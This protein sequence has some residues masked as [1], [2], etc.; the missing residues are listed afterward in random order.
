MGLRWL[1]DLREPRAAVHGSRKPAV[2]GKS[3]DF[4][5]TAG[6]AS[7]VEGPPRTAD[8]DQLRAAAALLHLFWVR[9]SVTVVLREGHGRQEVK[10]IMGF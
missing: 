4:P 6:W 2:R 1:A 10:G 3:A 7:R 5:R 8:Q 9:Q